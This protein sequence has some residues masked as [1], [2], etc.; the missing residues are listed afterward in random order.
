MSVLL[1]FHKVGLILVAFGAVNLLLL[2]VLRRRVR[3]QGGAGTRIAYALAGGMLLS[4]ITVGAV[5]VHLASPSYV[6]LH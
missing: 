4:A 2:V 6:Q 3:R 5:M 1:L